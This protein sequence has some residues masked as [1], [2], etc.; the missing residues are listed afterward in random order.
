MPISVNCGW[1]SGQCTFIDVYRW[2]KIISSL[3]LKMIK[4]M[5]IYPYS[6]PFF[7]RSPGLIFI[8]ISLTHQNRCSGLVVTTEQ[9]MKR[10]SW[11]NCMYFAAYSYMLCSLFTYFTYILCFS[12]W[13]VLCYCSGLYCTTV[14][15]LDC[16][17]AITYWLQWP[18]GEHVLCSCS[19]MLS[20][21]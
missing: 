16:I 20:G 12:S 19:D 21:A 15:H 8:K 2:G 4:K 5:N 6:T 3:Y 9:Q 13:L 17:V 1:I 18:V 7:F 14:L 11:K 10:S